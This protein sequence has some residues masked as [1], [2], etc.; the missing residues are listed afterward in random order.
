MKHTVKLWHVA[1][2]S[3]A[4]LLT[5]VVVG[6]VVRGWVTPPKPENIEANAHVLYDRDYA[7]VDEMMTVPNTVIVSGVVGKSA[8]PVRVGDG[9]LFTDRTVTVTEVLRGALTGP[10]QYQ[11]T[12]R[13][14]GGSDSE[15]HLAIEGQRLLSSDESVVLVLVHD[16]EHQRYWIVGGAHG[17]F[18]VVDG[19]LVHA[20]L[21]DS[22]HDLA[23]VWEGGEHPLAVF[24]REA[25]VADLRAS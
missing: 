17:C 18:L 19:G 4:L 3:T 2:A 7:S 21:D 14:T 9:V 23:A 6:T 12:V 22:E 1:L 5:G 13:Q 11:I 16:A 25:K 8:S 20:N 10:Q 15:G 24:A